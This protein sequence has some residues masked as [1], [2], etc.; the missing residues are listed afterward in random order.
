MNANLLLALAEI[1][2]RFN[3]VGIWS[4]GFYAP[5]DWRHERKD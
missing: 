4:V 1:K 2:S 3:K 5:S